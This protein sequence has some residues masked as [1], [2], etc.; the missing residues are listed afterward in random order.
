MQT[1][2][3]QKNDYPLLCAKTDY[4]ERIRTGYV[5]A[6]KASA[7]LKDNYFVKRVFLFGSLVDQEFF[8]AHSDIDIAVDGLPEKD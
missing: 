2:K 7:Y 3:P 8:H 1:I 5:E 4:S 6:A